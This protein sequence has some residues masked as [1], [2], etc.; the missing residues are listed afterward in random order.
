LL[1]NRTSPKIIKSGM[2]MCI[3]EH[4]PVLISYLTATTQASKVINKGITITG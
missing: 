4:L 3:S 2:G 1:V